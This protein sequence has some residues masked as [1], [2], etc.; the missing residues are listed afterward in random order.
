MLGRGCRSQ[1]NPDGFMI[2]IHNLQIKGEV[3]YEKIMKRQGTQSTAGFD[4]IILLKNFN[5]EIKKEDLI[6]FK[7][8][9]EDEEWKMNPDAFM[10]S[11]PAVAKKL[12]EEN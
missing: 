12:V 9:Y 2:L 8:A 10:E 7:Q 1:G 4:N 5:Q 3:V 6:K 11:H